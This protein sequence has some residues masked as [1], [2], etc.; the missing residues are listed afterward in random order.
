MTLVTN[1]VP[2]VTP[3][4][5]RERRVTRRTRNIGRMMSVTYALP[6][7]DAGKSRWPRCDARHLSPRTRDAPNT[8]DYMRGTTWDVPKR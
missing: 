5:R 8:W 3:G 7:R 1:R 2:D 6:T 4:T